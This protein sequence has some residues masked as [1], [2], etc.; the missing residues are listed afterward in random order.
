M[1]VRLVAANIQEPTD[2]LHVEIVRAEPVAPPP[3]PEPAAETEE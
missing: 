2:D 1:N 3:P